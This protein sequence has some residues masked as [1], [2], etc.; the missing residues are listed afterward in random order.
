MVVGGVE[1]LLVE[2][3]APSSLAFRAT[4]QSRVQGFKTKSLFL[5]PSTLVLL[6]PP[7]P[8]PPSG[9]CRLQ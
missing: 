6:S 5:P 9:P 1:R 3:F 7:R 8:S 4:D 2:A